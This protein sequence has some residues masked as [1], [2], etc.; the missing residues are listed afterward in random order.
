MAQLNEA[1]TVIEDSRPPDHQFGTDR[2]DSRGGLANIATTPD[3]RMVLAYLARRGDDPKLYL[4]L[5][6][7][8]I[9]PATGHPWCMAPK[10]WNSPDPG[11]SASPPSRLTEAGST[12]PQPERD[13]G[14]KR[15]RALPGVGNTR[16]AS[17]VGAETRTVTHKTLLDGESRPSCSG[18][19]SS[20]GSAT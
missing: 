6:E 19:G 10:W 17:R 8:T 18:P 5:G 11:S 4:R 20:Q 15:S 1:G 13:V 2:R 9:D 3:G 16:A 14:S 12:R 7:V